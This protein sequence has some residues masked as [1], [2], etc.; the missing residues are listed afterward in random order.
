MDDFIPQ[1]E[2][3]EALVRA[4][5]D[6]A[7]RPEFFRTLLESKI[8]FLTPPAH[9]T[10]VEGIFAVGSTLTFVGWKGPQGDYLPFFSSEE[11]VEE[12]AR[13][14]GTRLGIVGLRGRDAF[15]L[16][17]QAPMPVFLNP[18]LPYGKT[19]SVD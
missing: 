12:I 16:L 15:H 9:E 1:N 3:E 19:F 10:R 13:E 5:T 17:G 8:Y 14:L 7:A 4:A 11:R 6:P 18:R 2:L